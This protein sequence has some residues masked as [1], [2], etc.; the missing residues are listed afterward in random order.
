M[1]IIGAND[2]AENTFADLVEIA[3]VDNGIDNTLADPM[4]IAVVD[5]GIG[6]ALANSMEIA[7]VDPKGT[8]SALNGAKVTTKNVIGVEMEDL[9]EE[10]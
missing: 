10:D 3:M 5:D 7:M 8:K 1:W 6:S 4:E 9:S 2:E